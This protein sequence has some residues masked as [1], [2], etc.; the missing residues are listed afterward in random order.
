MAST[1]VG[2]LD[3]LAI[4][5]GSFGLSGFFPLAPATFASALAAVGLWLVYP[6]NSWGAYA[7]AIALVLFVGVWACGRMER[8]YG[9]DPSAAV[10]DEVCGMVITLTGAPINAA[11]LL[12]GFVLFRFFDIVKV[13][14]GRRSERLPG[15]WGVMMDDVVAG[16]YAFLGVQLALRLWPDM[17]LRAWH[18][19]VIGAA[20]LVL[21][22]F[23]KPLL[24]RYGKPRTRLGAVGGEPRGS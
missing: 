8:L 3:R 5:L 6:F 7:L 22:V 18:A 4:V 19:L 14:P 24:R 23:R 9:P 17:Q 1:R 13:P 20:G 11:T 21:F 12:L 2:G 10:V 16:V 15:G